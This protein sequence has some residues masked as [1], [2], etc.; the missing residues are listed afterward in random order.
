MERSRRR[1]KQARPKRAL[2]STWK[3][4]LSTYTPTRSPS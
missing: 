4:R 1:A 2:V 3:K